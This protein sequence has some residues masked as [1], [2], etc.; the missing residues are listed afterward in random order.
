MDVFFFKMNRGWKQTDELIAFLRILK[1]DCKHGSIAAVSQLR[2]LFILIAFSRDIAYGKGE[3]DIAYEMIYGFYKVFPIL[4]IKAL[5]FILLEG[6]GS[7]NDIKYFCLA[8]Q[9]KGDADALID[10]AISIATN[11]LHR[12]AYLSQRS[13]VAKW[14]PRESRH[15]ELYGRF[16]DAWGG[17]KKSYR[18]MISALSCSSSFSQKGCNI[19]MGQYVKMALLSGSELVDEQWC[20][21]LRSFGNCPN[22]IA[23]VD[24]DI[25]ID[26]DHLYHALGFACFIAEK[27]GS[28]RVLLVSG[29]PFWVDLSVCSGFCDR[30]RLLWSYCEIRTR[31]HFS[32][33]ID[34]ILGAVS[35][36]ACESMRL[37]IFSETFAFDEIADNRLQIILWNIGNKIGYDIPVGGILMS[38]YAPCLMRLFSSYLWQN[39]LEFVSLLTMDDRYKPLRD[40]FD[41]SM[42]SLTKSSYSLLD[43]C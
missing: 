41:S 19:F 25:E 38:G 4:A 12:D 3:R 31:S 6:I 7:W 36:L 39:S 14:I 23:V 33:A 15:P 13:N 24:I 28:M 40:Y 35:T 10:V 29:V 21:L 11:Q 32:G 1:Y 22:S 5:H 27:S 26:N 43:T 17:R 42:F 9:N 34:L 30:V 18:K 8:M 37:F 2:T 20:R 16:V